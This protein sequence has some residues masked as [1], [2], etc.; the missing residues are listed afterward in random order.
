MNRKE[1]NEKKKIISENIDLKNER[2]T[3]YEVEK[4]YNF[5]NNFSD[6]EGK[7]KNTKSRHNSFSSDGK[8]SSELNN[9]YTIK[10]DDSGIHVEQKQHYHDDDGKDYETSIKHN[11]GR[12]ILQ[13]LSDIFDL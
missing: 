5:A 6:Y 10:K 7:E 9:R 13:L 1:K 11:S 8:F 12:N 2:Y 4:L 3:D